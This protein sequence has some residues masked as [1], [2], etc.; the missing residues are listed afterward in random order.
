MSLLLRFLSYIFFVLGFIL[1][2][3]GLVF[4]FYS[5]SSVYDLSRYVFL[6]LFGVLLFALGF[7][8]YEESIYREV[9]G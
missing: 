8:L 2:L 7:V 4:A 6:C 9:Y 1:F 3:F 5:I